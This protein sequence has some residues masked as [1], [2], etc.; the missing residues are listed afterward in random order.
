MGQIGARA[1]RQIGDSFQIQLERRYGRR[2]A[3]KE[4]LHT[5]FSLVTVRYIVDRLFWNSTTKVLEDS[6]FSL[7]SYKSAF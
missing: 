4:E 7:K 3:A 1:L 6:L 2:T 5:G